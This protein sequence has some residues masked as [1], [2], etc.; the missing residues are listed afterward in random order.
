M[1]KAGVG[2]LKQFIYLFL[3]WLSGAFSC[4]VYAQKSELTSHVHPLYLEQ[5]ADTDYSYQVIFDDEGYLWAGTDNS[6]KRYDG[7]QVTNFI[8]DPNDPNSISSNSIEALLYDDGILW[9]G[10]TSL[11]KYHPETQSF[12][13]YDVSGSAIIWSLYKDDTN[14]MWVGGEGFGLRGFDLQKKEIVHEFFLN[15]DERFIYEIVPILNSTK[16]WISTSKGL[17]L[18]DTVNFSIE[19]YFDIQKSETNIQ[20]I[21][22]LLIDHQGYIWMVSRNG[23]IKLNPLDKSIT[24]YRHNPAD[25][26]SIS[27]NTLWSIYQDNKKRIWIG[28]DKKGINLYDEK[29][30]G[31]QHISA[32]LNVQDSFKFPSVAINDIFQDTNNSLWFATGQGILR[33]SMHLD[34]F[35]HLK[36]ISGDLNSLNF[37]N[38][39]DLHQDKKGD[40]WIATDGGG[41]DKYQPE[42]EK[43]THYMYASEDSSSLSSDSVIAIDEDEQGYLWLGTYAGGLSRFNPQTGEFKRFMHDSEKPS[44][45]TIANNNIFR[46]HVAHDQK[47]WLSVWRTGLQVYDPIKDEFTSYFPLGEGKESG[48]ANFNITDIEPDGQGNFWVSGYEGLEYFDTETSTFTKVDFPELERIFDV[49]VDEDII[50]LATADG[51]VKY[52]YNA[53][54]HQIFTTLNGL[55]DNFVTTI[56]KDKQGVF[57]LG[58]KQGINSFDPNTLAVKNFTTSEGLTSNLF[59][60]FSHLHTREGKMY[61]GGP[62]GINIFDPQNMPHNE[63]IPNVVLTNFDIHH[64]TGSL[65]ENSVLNKHIGLT[66]HV[67]L[68]YLQNDLIIEFAALGFISPDKN[69]YKYKLV[70]LEDE[71]NEVGALGRD[72]RYTNLSP[73]TYT[74]QVMASNSEGVWNPEPRELSINIFP[75]W[76]NTWW[77]YVVFIFAFIGGIYLYIYRS[78]L[79]NKKMALALEQ[80]VKDRTLELKNSHDE[81]SGSLESLK[82]TKDQLVQSEKMASLGA[83]VAGVA[84]EVNTPVGIC[85]TANTHL[86][87]ITQKLCNKVESNQLTKKDFIQF[88]DEVNKSV[89]LSLSNISRAAELINSFKKIAVEQ[90]SELPDT[91]LLKQKLQDCINTMTSKLSRSHTS[92]ELICPEELKVSSYPGVLSQII[93]NF[94]MNSITHGFGVNEKGNITISVKPTNNQTYLINYQDNGK[95]IDKKHIAFVFEPFFTTNRKEGNSGLGMHIVYNLVTQKLNGNIDIIPKKSGVE[96]QLE[97]PNKIITIK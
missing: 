20:V 69:A 15:E 97:L 73:G 39:L 28:S 4:G 45:K 58:T 23:V 74:F 34:R 94:I 88:K 6:L 81:L 59:N 42:I 61:F 8:H 54:T 92:L 84:H 95:G 44:M 78:T 82:R 35:Q 60:R 57:W 10:G 24:H 64:K 75:P 72:V 91:F 21:E 50:W 30:D 7:Y 22:D 80:Q 66:E 90:T 18:F 2:V 93:I 62:Q 11:N 32:V 1:N 77:A 87:Y 65:T 71:W 19:Y 25:A 29:I 37:N 56:E 17:A 76:W 26:Y 83:L 3:L 96:F 38:V 40:I 48:I 53:G 41:L 52:N 63:M 27:S 43:F 79:K 49:F 68:T 86:Q 85:L 46:V 14:I 51:F 89:E 36:N 33:V 13:N 55:A 5:G 47:V 31:F 67:D 70:G 9:A 16:L 12:T